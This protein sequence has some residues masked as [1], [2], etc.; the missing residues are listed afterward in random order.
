LANTIAILQCKISFKLIQI[1]IRHSGEPRPILT[2]SSGSV[3]L[4]LHRVGVDLSFHRRRRQ[5]G[6]QPLSIIWIN[7]R[8]PRGRYLAE[9]HLSS[10]KV[11]WTILL[12]DCVQV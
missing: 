1:Y 5:K 4:S 8:C 10:Y 11:Q 9:V 2:T 3:Q 12:H 6:P 7:K